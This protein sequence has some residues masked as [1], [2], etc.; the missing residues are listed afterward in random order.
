MEVDTAAMEVDTTAMAPAGT[1]TI[2]VT[3][4]V[5]RTVVEDMTT[6]TAVKADTVPATVDASMMML[7]PRLCK[8]R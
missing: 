2:K 7:V 4:E 6:V 8:L 1:A 3:E 5:R